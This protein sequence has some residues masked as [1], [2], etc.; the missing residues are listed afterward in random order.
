MAK[1]A[2]M[3]AGGKM[4]GRIT[5]NLMKTDHDVRYVE[6]SEPGIVQLKEK[7]LDA[8]TAEQAVPD[9]DHVIMA[10]PDVAIGSVAKGVVP[11]MKPGAMVVA[12]DPAAP[13]A[14]KYPE[15][16]DMTYFAAHPAHPS[17]FNV[18]ET[19]EAQRDHFGGIHAKQCVVCALMH[20]PEEDYAKGEALVRQMWAPVTKTYRIT[21]E[22]M[23]L[24]EPALVETT[25]LTLINVMKQ[26]TDEIVRLGVPAEAAREFVLGHIHVELAIVFEEIDAQVSDGAKLAMERAEAQLM[27]PDW[28]KLL[29]PDS[30]M[31]Q[32]RAITG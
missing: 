19:P 29:Q 21:L 27:Q 4:G 20:G 7:G 3:G 23:G 10:V 22:Q 28:K 30:M 18:E 5:D 2:L 14:G 32:V 25:T 12:L 11:G 15:R 17:V 31:E 26:A 13:L 16:E 1:I 8:V 6:I 9:A 24:L